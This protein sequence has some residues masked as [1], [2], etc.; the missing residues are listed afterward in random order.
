LIAAAHPC[1]PAASAGRCGSAL[2]ARNLTTGETV[3][4]KASADARG[5]NARA[6]AAPDEHLP[7]S[8]GHVG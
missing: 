6:A 5:A 1:R 7:A 8:P 3:A 2:L 4:V